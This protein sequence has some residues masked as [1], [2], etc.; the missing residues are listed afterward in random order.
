MKIGD[1]VY[2][3]N[4]GNLQNRQK[5]V[6][7]TPTTFITD[8]GTKLKINH[9]GSITLVGARSFCSYSYYQETEDLK[10]KWQRDMLC[11]RLKAYDYSN[12]SLETL[13]KVIELLGYKEV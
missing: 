11:R 7:A 5:I 8:K 12:L 4:Y 9:L 6:R 10:S 3:F 13:K 2:E 1:Y